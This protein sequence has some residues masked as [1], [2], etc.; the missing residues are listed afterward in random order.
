MTEADRPSLQS[1]IAAV[2]R[3]LPIADLVAR[4]TKLLGG[5]KQRRCICPFHQGSSA[6]FAVYPGAGRAYCFGCQW[7]GDVIGY[8][9]DRKGLSFIDALAECEREAGLSDTGA[10][11][12]GRGPVVRARNP[13]GAARRTREFVEPLVLARLLWRISRAEPDKVHRYFTGRGVPDAVLTPARLAAFRY[14]GLGPVMP[15]EQ[16]SGPASVPQAPALV[17]LVRVPQLLPDS[18]GVER[19]KFLPVGVHVTF[20]NPDGTGTMIRRKPWAKRDDPDPL[21]PKRKMLGPGGRGCVLLGD[22]GPAA[23]LWVG[24]GNETVLSA[25]ALAG[26]DDAAVGVATLSLD[27]LQGTPAKWR[28]G[29]LPLHAIECARPPFLIHG[30]SG[31]VTGLIDSDMSPLRGPLD[32]KTGQY[33][34]LLLVERKG[35]PLLRR[36]ITG[37]ERARICGELLVK[38][39]RAAGAGPVEALRAPMGMDFNDAVRCAA[40]R[41]L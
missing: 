25:M 1:R 18:D 33:L 41:S 31:P 35:G 23:R 14:V 4:D 37:A 26:A 39:W 15:W 27:N 10:S 19:L 22:Y 38:G 21:M 30:H 6:S 8:V 16:G 20:L 9:R 12:A 36:A 17:A 29:A 7:T 3:E 28:N 11:A 32:P 24:E 40:G 5:V 34:G 13:A 2:R